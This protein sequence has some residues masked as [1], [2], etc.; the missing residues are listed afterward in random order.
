M[1]RLP[2]ALRE[3]ESGP[4]T[5][6]QRPKL[7][8]SLQTSPHLIHKHEIMFA[9]ALASVSPTGLQPKG[10]ARGPS[11]GQRLS[12]PLAPRPAPCVR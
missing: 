3:G 6:R 10:G 4:R 5:G 8:A 1:A 11:S 12:Q 7:S 2:E 9:A